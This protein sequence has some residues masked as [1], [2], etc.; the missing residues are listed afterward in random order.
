M[1][2]KDILTGYHQGDFTVT[3]TMLAILQLITEENVQRVVE[4]LPPDVR[5]A[6]EY[7]VGY[8]NLDVGIYNGPRPSVAAVELVKAHFTQHRFEQKSFEGG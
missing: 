6:T 2:L 4:A 1:T 3:D 5:V 8:Y 7:F